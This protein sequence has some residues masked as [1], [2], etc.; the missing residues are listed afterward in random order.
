MGFD[1]GRFLRNVASAGTTYFRDQREGKREEQNARDLIAENTALAQQ[2][3]DRDYGQSQWEDV[4]FDPELRAAQDDAL[5]RM[6]GLSREGFTDLD[7]QALD[8]GFMQ[9]RREEQAQRG[10]VMDAAARRGDTSGGN[11]LLASLAAGQGGANRASQ[12]ATD[13]GL[14]G[15]ERALNALE[16]YGQQAGQMQAQDVG[17]QGARAGGLDSFNQWATGQRSADAALLMN[18]RTGQAQSVQQHAADLQASPGA[19]LA[20]QAGLAYATGGASVAAPAVTNM[21]DSPGAKGLPQPGGQGPTAA[22][23]TGP[24]Q[25]GMPGGAPERTTTFG[26]APRFGTGVLQ[27]RRQRRSA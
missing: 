2:M 25:K 3:F 26:G 6:E 16:S 1:V 17:L 18:A 24:Q 8:Q 10:A 11:A 22:P 27:A 19:D 4:Q 9:S 15:R 7:R 12:Y 13:I 21:V 23:P 20:I 5:R 14:A